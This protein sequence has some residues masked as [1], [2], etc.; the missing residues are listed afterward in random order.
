M[1]RTHG[2]ST[3]SQGEK[4]IEWRAASIIRSWLPMEIPENRNW[5]RTKIV[6]T[7]GPATDQP[8]VIERLIGGGMDV[9]RVNTSHGDHADHVS[10]I[11][12]VRQAAKA[13]GQPVA[14]LVD[15]PGPKFRVGDLP[16]GSLELAEGA[17]VTLAEEGGDPG[18]GNNPLPVRNREL[19]QA[20]RAGESVFLVDGSIEL[21]V[22]TAGAKSTGSGVGCEVVIGGTVRSGSGVNVPESAL[23]TLIPTDDDRRHLAF[24]V[25]QEVEWVGVSFV[26]SAGDIARVR[27]CLPAGPG[28]APLLMAKIEKRRALADLDAIVEA[29]DGV[30]VARGDLGVETDLAGI[31]IVQKRI[32]AAANARGRPVVTATQMLESMVEHEHPTR[33]EVTDVANAV[34]DGTDAVMLSAETAIGR[35]PIAAARMLYRVLA[36]T[37]KEYGERMAL[38]QMHSRTAGPPD[39]AM[40]FAA[41]LLAARLGLRAIIVRVHTMAAVLAIARFRPQAP[42][43]MVADSERLYRSLALVRGVSPLFLAAAAAADEEAGPEACLA[44]ASAW[45]T[46]Q[47]LAQPGDQAVLVSASGTAHDKADTL[48]IVHLT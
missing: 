27:A 36:A 1:M 7:L 40:S 44:Q 4:A 22:T 9:A 45:L 23:D 14:I 30:M 31:P 12:R 10:R 6:C 17:I 19:L 5:Q 37:E 48:R 33:A 28:M 3:T 43:V 11:R 32:I 39:D 13:L 41:C 46:S 21:R 38:E 25:S 20:L 42:L 15:L 29:S 2:C 35:S 16:G 47:G 18:E 34:L 24:A 26:Q 8:G